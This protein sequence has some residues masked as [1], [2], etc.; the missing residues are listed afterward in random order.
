MDDRI[1]MQMSI[2][3][4]GDH[5][6][7]RRIDLVPRM[8]SVAGADLPHPIADNADVCTVARATSSV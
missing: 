1:G 6:A 7:P 8:R 2:D 5:I 4:S 3:E